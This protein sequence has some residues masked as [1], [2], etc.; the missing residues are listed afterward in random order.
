MEVLTHRYLNKEQAIE[1]RLSSGRTE[2]FTG[3]SIDDYTRFSRVSPGEKLAFIFRHFLGK[4]P[5]P[6]DD[7]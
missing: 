1:V 4:E 2:R 7:K 6:K 3:V 5:I